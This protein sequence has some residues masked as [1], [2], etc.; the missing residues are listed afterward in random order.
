MT[1]DKKMIASSLKGS[2][3]AFA[4]LVDKY[5]SFVCSLAYC[6][7]GDFHISEDV[8][9]DVFISVWKELPSLQDHGKFKSWLTSITRNTAISYIKKEA[10]IPKVG[11]VDIEQL[12]ATSPAEDTEK[13]DL[14]WQTLEALPAEYRES[15]VLYY[16]H[17]KSA[18]QVAEMMEITPEAVRQRLSRGREMIREEV[19]R[20]L[21]TGLRNTA[22]GKK[23]TASVIAAI[24]TIPIGSAITEASVTTAAVAQSP[25][26]AAVSSVLSTAAIKIAAVLITAAAI[27]T[28]I[29][30]AQTNKPN[31]PTTPTIPAIA[32]AADPQPLPLPQ[33]EPAAP[34]PSPEPTETNNTAPAPAPTQEIPAVTAA[35]P[36]DF[37]PRG[38]LSGLITD[39]KTGEPV[40]DAQL[41]IELPGSYANTET[42]KNGFYFFDEDK[43]K[44]YGKCTLTVQSTEY[45]GLQPVYNNYLTLNI[46]SGSKAVQHIQLE[47]A[48][49]LYVEVAD[50]E[51]LPVKDV[52]V[53]VTETASI[54]DTSPQPVNA[55][56]IHTDKD[57]KAMTGG[58]KPSAIPYFITFV[59]ARY[60]K[61]KHSERYGFRYLIPIIDYAPTYQTIVLDNPEVIGS[62]KTVM[63]KGVDITGRLLYA[64]AVP[65]KDIKIG[66][67]PQWWH[68]SSSYPDAEVNEDGT[69]TIEHAVSGIND[70]IYYHIPKE[71]GSYMCKELSTALIEE[72][73]Y[74]DLVL[75]YASPSN[76]VA[77]AGKIIVE[78]DCDVSSISVD[79]T[80][81]DD[82]FQHSIQLQENVKE[83]DF[84]LYD[85]KPGIY[86][87][88]FNNNNIIN[89]SL[90]NIHIP[91]VGFECT[92]QCK[93]IINVSG[94]VIDKETQ[95][96]II[97]FRVFNR[98]IKSQTGNYYTDN[99]WINYPNADGGKFNF[100]LKDQGVHQFTIDSDGYA[101]QTIE[102]DTLKTTSFTAELTRG[103][104]L[105]GKV[106]G[107]DGQPVTN[108]KLIPFTKNAYYA[109][110]GSQTKLF[111]TNIGS[112]IT[113]TNGIFTLE[114][115][116]QGTETIKISHPDCSEKVIDVDL[117]LQTNN[118]VITLDTGCS[119]AGYVYD[120]SGNPRANFPLVAL[121]KVHG[122]YIF[123]DPGIAK[124]TTDKDGYYKLSNLPEQFLFISHPSVQ[125]TEGVCRNYILTEKGKTTIL[126]FGGTY[127]LTGRILLNGSPLS[128][129]D[130]LITDAV[131]SRKSFINNGHTLSDGSFVFSGIHEGRNRLV[132]KASDS[133]N[134]WIDIVEFDTK[135][136]DLNLGD[137]FFDLVDAELKIDDGENIE[138][139]YCSLFEDFAKTGRTFTPT[140]DG[141]I[142]AKSI[143]PGKYKVSLTR[144]SDSASLKC[145]IEVPQ[146]EKISTINIKLP[147]MTSSVY[148]KFPMGTID[149]DFRKDDLSF[150]V[151]SGSI[152]NKET[153]T[154]R[155]DNM[156]AGKYTV[157]SFRNGSTVVTI[158]ELM[159]GQALEL[160]LD[161]FDLA[162][163]ILPIA[164]IITVD[165]TTRRQIDGCEI[166]IETGGTKY[167]DATLSYIQAPPGTYTLCISC[168]GYKDYRSDIRLRA[169]DKSGYVKRQSITAVL[170]RQ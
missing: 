38:V 58:I 80:N 30:L 110:D 163:A 33:A 161:K 170:E 24:S 109:N 17:E 84:E 71:L 92:L 57:G 137:I 67:K 55:G 114:N 142:I 88:H 44:S 134:G 147:A 59:H 149:L 148:G 49:M 158:F 135:G 51:G 3:Q 19:E 78:G 136:L 52:F 53:A 47:K 157:E 74:L 127:Y 150:V 8:A 97:N 11:E 25:W 159:E 64:D 26:T 143:K 126:D 107:S 13:S 36:A 66:L 1:D 79:L 69:F 118:I 121:D 4:M 95:T 145:K 138:I 131:T 5:K 72:D 50:E 164:D 45:V 105:T 94:A 70:I 113:D 2:R 85:I 153:G 133:Q 165:G 117:P 29:I 155:I 101:P 73:K 62:V 48:C 169:D 12:P 144:I 89:K 18:A 75:P 116:P 151:S 98:V 6:T 152:Q 22:P 15:L 27:T 9:Q 87:V 103:V 77:F 41:H 10:S 16:R 7:T 31:P 90:Q 43:V 129:A 39:I 123:D 42:D 122:L 100:V 125:N 124:T 120:N 115:M 20:K 32:K 35:N 146:T 65:A 28:G 154:Y 14:V 140:A 111:Q 56:Y 93:D 112:V 106:L 82:F 104:A 130:L 139:K 119:V 76:L 37:T 99:S 68:S 166:W 167:K 60:D 108:A 23:F 63:K 83:T 156:P 91:S 54:S 21:E 160:D 168:P 40:I 61:N 128:N 46:I 96:P 141:V 102:L 132:Y 81:N 162:K 34:A 86:N